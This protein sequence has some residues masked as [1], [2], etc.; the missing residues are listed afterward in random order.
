MI[1]ECGEFL[2]CLRC[3]NLCTVLTKVLILSGFEAFF[4]FIRLILIRNKQSTYVRR[5]I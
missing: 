3:E 4:S 2:M 5:Y 1:F